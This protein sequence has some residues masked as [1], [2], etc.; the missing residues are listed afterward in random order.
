MNINIFK[1]E[2]MNID[3][4]EKK[5]LIKNCNNLIIDIKI[6]MKNHVDIYKIIRN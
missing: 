1:F 6:K 4:I 3:V 5:L 2:Y